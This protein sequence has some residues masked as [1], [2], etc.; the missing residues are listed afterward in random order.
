MPAGTTWEHGTL[1]GPKDGNDKANVYDVLTTD[2]R[3]TLVYST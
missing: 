2:S 1:C 3:K